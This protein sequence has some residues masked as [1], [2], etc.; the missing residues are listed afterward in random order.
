MFGNDTALDRLN[1]LKTDF[2]KVVQNPFD[3]SLAEKA[4]IDAWQLADWVYQ[5]KKADD[6]S[7]TLQAFREDLYESFPNIKI[8]HDVANTVKHKTLDRPQVKIVATENHKGAFSSD[9]SMDYDISVIL[10]SVEKDDGTIEK[11]GVTPL[12]KEAIEYWK[13]VLL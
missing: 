7:L 2:E 3:I 11:H 4:C 1:L 13:R 9:F 8:L 10:I 6:D 5:E 12:L